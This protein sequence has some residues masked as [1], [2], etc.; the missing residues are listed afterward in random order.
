MRTQLARLGLM[1]PAGV[2]K[3]ATVPLCAICAGYPLFVGPLVASG[4]ISSG[5]FLHIFIPVLMPLNIW[6]LRLGLRDHGRPLGLILAI[7]S[8]PFIVAHLAGHFIFGGDERVLLALIWAGGGLLVAGILADWQAQRLASR[9]ASCATPAG[10]WH[11]VLSG[12]HPGLRRGRRFF[13]RLPADPRCSLC[14][15]PFAGPFAWLMRR[16]GKGAS[17]RNPRFCSD[18]LTNAPLGG[19]EVELSLLFA[20]VRGSTGLAERLRPAEFA[21]EM[22]RFYVAG[23][24]A[25]IRTDALIDKFM[26]DE[27]IGLYVPGFAGPHHALLAIQ[28]AQALQRATGDDPDGSRLPV[29]I[30]VH[31]GIAYVGAVGSEGTVS[32]ITVLG[33]IA[34][35]TARLASAAGPGEI[36]VSTAACSAAGLAAEHFERRDLQLKGRNEAVQVVC[37]HADPLAP[38]ISSA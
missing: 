5:A 7:A 8:M 30:G 6:L 29:G 26:G 22:N 9:L 15:A 13:G 12:E 37:M 23:T 21:A 36:L 32:D 1:S 24:A 4:V 28:A 38:A 16:I 10:Y 18:C 17:T 27:V 25:L 34:N 19:A 11:A 14:Y 31:T 3:T 33:D 35:T 20:D 2:V